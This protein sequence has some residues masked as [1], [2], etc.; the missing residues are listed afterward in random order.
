MTEGAWM[1][2]V[3]FPQEKRGL[4]VICI[5]VIT[6]NR[7]TVES[8]AYRVSGVIHKEAH[9]IESKENVEK[10]RGHQRHSC[11]S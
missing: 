5:L 3:S 4:I 9:H 6:T 7:N 2:P 1:A 11:N 10:L 8:G